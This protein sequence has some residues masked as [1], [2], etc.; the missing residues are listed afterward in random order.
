MTHSNSDNT[1]LVQTAKRVQE[2]LY[3]GTLFKMGL[4]L[5]IVTVHMYFHLNTGKQLSTGRKCVQGRKRVGFMDSVGT[6]LANIH[7]IT[8]SVKLSAIKQ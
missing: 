4:G 7:S 5:G 1:P 8:G 3:N 6:I 2:L